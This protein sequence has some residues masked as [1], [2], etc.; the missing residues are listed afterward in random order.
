MLQHHIPW[1]GGLSSAT[2]SELRIFVCCLISLGLS[3]LIYK[4]GILIQWCSG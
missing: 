1:V 4:E 3:F 2:Y